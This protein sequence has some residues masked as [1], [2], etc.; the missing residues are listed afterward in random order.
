MSCML[1]RIISPAEQWP[2]TDGLQRPLLR[3]SRFQ[4]QLRPGVRSTSDILESRDKEEGKK[5]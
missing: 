5:A 2:R 1:H 3:R 4:P